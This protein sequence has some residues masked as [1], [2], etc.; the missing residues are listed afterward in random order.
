[1]EAWIS[2]R[3]K[4]R[5]FRF[6][7]NTFLFLPQNWKINSELWDIHL[8]FWNINSQIHKLAGPN[9]EI[10]ILN[11][12]LAKRPYFLRI[13]NLYLWCFACK[14]ILSHL[15]LKMLFGAT[16]AFSSTAQNWSHLKVVSPQ[17]DGLDNFTFLFIYSKNR[18]YIISDNYSV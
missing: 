6:W 13:S 7:V 17:K 5:A 4:K 15:N 18:I 9:W 3:K 14:I 10:E 11:L 16:E 8:E 1:M 2:L 12:C